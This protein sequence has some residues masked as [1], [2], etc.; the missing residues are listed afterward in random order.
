M[1]FPFPGHCPNLG[2]K[3]MSPAL[4]DRFVTTE[5]P[6]KPTFTPSHRGGHD[7]THNHRTLSVAA[8][9]LNSQGRTMGFHPARSGVLQP[10]YETL[11]PHWSGSTRGLDQ[12]CSAS[13]LLSEPGPHSG[14]LLH[15]ETRCPETSSGEPLRVGRAH[16]SAPETA[17]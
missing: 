2:I 11:T 14:N 9:G 17:A 10:S 5:P 15:T 1:L 13:N 3:P 7:C 16:P 12:S 8:R 4:A 6:E